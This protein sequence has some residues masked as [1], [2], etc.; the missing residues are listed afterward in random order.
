MLL[1]ENFLDTTRTALRVLIIFLLT[2]REL[3]SDQQ[4]SRPYMYTKVHAV[5]VKY[6]AVSAM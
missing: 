1:P 4:K 6:L 3:M 2:I 5:F